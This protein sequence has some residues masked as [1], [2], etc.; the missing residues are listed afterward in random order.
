MASLAICCSQST[1]GFVRS[2]LFSRRD[3]Q[4]MAGTSPISATCPPKPMAGKSREISG[5]SAGIICASAAMSNP[6]TAP[7]ISSLETASKSERSTSLASASPGIFSCR[8]SRLMPTG[9]PV[10]FA[11]AIVTLMRSP[12]REKPA[13]STTGPEELAISTPSRML[14]PALVRATWGVL[15]TITIGRIPQILA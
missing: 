3:S 12:S 13:T 7:M 5:E 11:G 4:S 10:V 2:S 6:R 1:K 14:S 8:I 9:E 15:L